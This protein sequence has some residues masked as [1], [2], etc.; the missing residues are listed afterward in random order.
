MKPIAYS[1]PTEKT[2]SNGI[3]CMSEYSNFFRNKSIADYLQ[4][5]GF[6]STLEAFKNEADI[7]S[8]ILNDFLFLLP[9]NISSKVRFVLLHNI[10]SKCRHKR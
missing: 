8:V 10:I 3:F 6:H 2:F 4:A 5:C 1:G 9:S 7:V